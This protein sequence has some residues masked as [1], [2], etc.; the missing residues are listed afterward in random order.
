M[1]LTELE[2]WHLLL[3]VLG[4]VN[5]LVIA[6][7]L[8]LGR[9]LYSHAANPYL[10]LFFA[11]LAVFQIND[12]FS[13][14]NLPSGWWSWLSLLCAFLLAPALYSYFRLQ[15]GP[16]TP[17]REGLWPHF[18]LALLLGGGASYLHAHNP[19][20]WND[21]VSQWP[22]LLLFFYYLPLCRY[23]V[24]FVKS[25]G[26]VEPRSRWLIA[27]F[28]TPLL[29]MLFRTALPYLPALIDDITLTMRF[30]LAQVVLIFALS[31][32]AV[33]LLARVIALRLADTSAGG[34][35]PQLLL[36]RDELDYI[37]QLFTGGTAGEISATPGNSGKN[38]QK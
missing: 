17:A 5:C 8:L 10:S 26:I 22:L 25:N 21:I 37:H 23:L 36:E 34:K 19:L 20:L 2:L 12:I 35:G 33:L 29:L 4:I 27:V 1:Y 7:L 32:Y 31:V 6:L 30:R 9:Q 28:L 13:V 24:R 15:L 14:L 18:V 11:L 16:V 38:D 3:N